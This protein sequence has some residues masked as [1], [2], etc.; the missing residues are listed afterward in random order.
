MVHRGLAADRGVDLSEERGWH[1]NEVD[2]T[3]IAGRREA[4]HVA[5][6]AAPQSH[7]RGVP[8]M[9]LL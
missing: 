2:P 3:L 8:R 5:H 9:A 7:K 6:D 1:L 4:D